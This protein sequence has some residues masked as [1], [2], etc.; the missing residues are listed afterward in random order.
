MQNIGDKVGTSRSM[1]KPEGWTLFDR[2]KF[3]QRTRK[4]TCT[5]TYHKPASVD[6]HSDATIFRTRKAF[7]G[8]SDNCP[9]RSMV[10]W[11]PSIS[12]PGRNCDNGKQIR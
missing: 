4:L 5:S 9:G 11:P 8:T 2:S 1:S 6:G 3:P 10:K 12:R 7:S